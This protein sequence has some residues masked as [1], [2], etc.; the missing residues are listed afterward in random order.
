MEELIGANLRVLMPEAEAARH[1]SYLAAH[2]AGAAPRVIGVPGRELLG[3][4]RNGSEF[5]IDL[6]VSSFSTNGAHRLTGI[7]RDATS[8][9]EADVALR[10]S[11]ARL[12]MVLQVGGIAFSDQVLSNDRTFVSDEFVELF[13]LTSG[14][15]NIVAAE[16]LTRSFPDREQM[17][18]KDN[19]DACDQGARFRRRFVSSEATSRYVRSACAGRSYASRQAVSPDQ[20]VAG[21]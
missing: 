11:E 17:A 8:R 5:P 9:K 14:R 15:D 7:I 16:L 13:G 6:S 12:R 2:R 18:A 4:R 20:C 10:E 3:I 21:R 1:D 19:Q